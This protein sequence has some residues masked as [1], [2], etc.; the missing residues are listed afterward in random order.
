MTAI[1]WM[2]Q[3]SIGFPTMDPFFQ[4]W[5]RIIPIFGRLSTNK[6]QQWI[7]SILDYSGSFLSLQEK[8]DDGLSRALKTSQRLPLG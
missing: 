8:K 5:I 4:P 2:V 3:T 6:F 7:I 1:F